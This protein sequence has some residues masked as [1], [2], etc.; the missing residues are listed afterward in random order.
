MSYTLCC[1]G[2]RFQ[3][4]E[5]NIIYIMKNYAI[6]FQLPEIV[7]HPY[8]KKRLTLPTYQVTG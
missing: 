5:G 2:Q 6:M 7:A 4:A 1:V 8:P 3:A